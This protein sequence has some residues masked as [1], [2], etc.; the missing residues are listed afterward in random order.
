MARSNVRTWLPLDRWAEIIGIHP[1]HFNGLTLDSLPQD[2]ICGMVWFQHS[3]QHADRVGHEDLAIAIQQAEQQIAAEVGYNLLPDWTKEERIPYA[4]PVQPGVYNLNGL[5]PR[6]MLNSVELKRGHVI[7]GGLKTKSVISAGE[8][9]VRTDADSDGFAETC[10]VTVATT[11]T[12][13]NEIALFYPAKNGEDAWEIRPIKVSFSG[14]NAIITFNVWLIS[15]ANQMSVFDAEP[16]DADLDASFESTVDVYRV[17]NDPSTQV[18]FMWENGSPLSCC[19]GTS[20]CLAC[21]FGT[22]AGCFH[23]REPRIGIAVPAPGSWDSDNDR[24]NAAEWGGCRGPDQARFW[25]Y[26]GFEDKNLTRSKVEM[27]SYWEYAVAFYA[28]SL[29]DRSVCGCSNVQEFIDKWRMDVSMNEFEGTTVTVTPELLMNKLGT[30][31]GAIYAWKRVQQ[32]GVRI[33][34]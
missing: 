3:W 28:A 20:T 23:L 16:L 25:Y 12:D 17:Y 5:N 13:A 2:T 33:L 26:S 4:L 30:T 1:L 22:Q 32:N 27:A 18:Q 14:G 8:S 6:G 10:T 11:I 24:F 21:Q 15:A 31:V 34:K 9:Y 19:C 7:S 29:L